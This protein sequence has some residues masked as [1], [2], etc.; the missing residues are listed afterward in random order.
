[1]SFAASKI[2]VCRMPGFSPP[3]Q[4][5]PVSEVKEQ[6]AGETSQKHR[7]QVSIDRT[8]HTSASWKDRTLDS[9]KKMLAGGGVI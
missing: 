8:L 5:S 3:N 9:V 2:D 1:M 4:L 6:Q 7:L